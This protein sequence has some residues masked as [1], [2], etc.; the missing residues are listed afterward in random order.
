ML[1]CHGLAGAPCPGRGGHQAGAGLVAAAP[2]PG[3]RNYALGLT[4]DWP[5]VDVTHSAPSTYKELWPPPLPPPP[6]QGLSERGLQP[7]SS[8]RNRHDRWR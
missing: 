2:A 5:G 4:T 8:W 6:G 1:H 3:A 7:N